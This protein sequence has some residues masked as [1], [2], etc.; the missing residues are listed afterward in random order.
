MNLI[1]EAPATP[2]PPPPPPPPP[3]PPPSLLTVLSGG[4]HITISNPDQLTAHSTLQCDGFEEYL[5]DC[6]SFT[7][8]ICH[9]DDGG[10]VFCFV[11]WCVQCMQ[12]DGLV[13][14][15]SMPVIQWPHCSAPS[16]SK[17]KCDCSEQGGVAPQ[18]LPR[19]P[20]ML[21]LLEDQSAVLHRRLG[22]ARHLGLLFSCLGCDRPVVVP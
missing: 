9:K 20:Q 10:S 15:L 6:P 16:W 3:R 14:V 11:L 21:L 7:H 18:P 12:S 17:N 4:G 22:L 2:P 1:G 5:I 8:D 19:L 13:G